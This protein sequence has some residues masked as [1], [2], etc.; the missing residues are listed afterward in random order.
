[1]GLNVKTDPILAVAHV[2][3]CQKTSCSKA[4]ALAYLSNCQRVFSLQRKGKWSTSNIWPWWQN[5]SQRRSF[6]FFKLSFFLFYPL[7]VSSICSMPPLLRSCNALNNVI[8]AVVDGLHSQARK[9][10][11]GGR[12]NGLH[13]CTY[14][15]LMRVQWVGVGGK[16]L[17]P[18]WERGKWSLRAGVLWW[19]SIL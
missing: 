1:M 14:I 12:R 13:T 10:Y 17:P 15:I 3:Y 16:G 2:M 7:D 18:E 11:T 8:I 9:Q 4:L 19:Q 6:F 5:H